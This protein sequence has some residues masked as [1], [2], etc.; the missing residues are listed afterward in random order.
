MQECD[1]RHEHD[2]FLEVLGC[3]A[4]LDIPAFDYAA[5]LAATGLHDVLARHAAAAA[6]PDDVLLEVVMATGVLCADEAAASLLVETGLVSG[7]CAAPCSWRVGLCCTWQGLC[8]A[9]GTPRAP[10]K[11]AFGCE[12]AVL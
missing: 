4:N 3:L 10:G 9:G 2:L 7:R 6:T 11:N 1:Q 12:R 5:L 8:I